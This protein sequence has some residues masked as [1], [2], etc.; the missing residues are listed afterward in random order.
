MGRHSVDITGSPVKYAGRTLVQG[1]FRDITD[2]KRM[3]DELKMHRDHLGKLVG[4][5]T[6]RIREEVARRKKKEEQY[7]ALVES[8]REWIW[9]TDG[10]FVHTY[11]SPRVYDVLGYS[12]GGSDREEPVDFIPRRKGPGDA[13]LKDLLSR[14]QP[15]PPFRPWPATKRDIPYMFRRAAFLILMRREASSAIAA[16]ARTS[17][18]RRTW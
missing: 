2:H 14:K 6:A 11:V 15:L 7:L 3:E 1:I 10:D 8:V 13:C 16:A 4:E 17:R 12:P 18:S 5:R 9:E